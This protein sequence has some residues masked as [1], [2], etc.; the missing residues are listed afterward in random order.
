MRFVLC[1]SVLFHIICHCK[2][3]DNQLDACFISEYKTKL[4]SVETKLSESESERL[5][6]IALVGT[7]YAIG[8]IKCMCI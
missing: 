7:G 2:T 1:E 3:I 4:N 5:G 8:I 6:E